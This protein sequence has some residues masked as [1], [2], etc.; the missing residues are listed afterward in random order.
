MK[1]IITQPNFLPWLGY[2]DRMKIADNFVLL[3]TVQHVK[4]EVGN[5]EIELLIAKAN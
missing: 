2:I 3:D 4:K 5:L 1:T